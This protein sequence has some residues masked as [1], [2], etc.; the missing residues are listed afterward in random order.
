MASE[1]K[2][3][4][5]ARGS[6]DE[7]VAYF[8]KALCDKMGLT[9]TD[10][11]DDV[12]DKLRRYGGNSLINP[13][14]GEGVSYAEL[15][16]DVACKL[17]GVFEERPFGDPD[18]T[19]CERYVLGKM[20][21]AEDDLDKLCTA[22]RGKGMGKAV[23]GQVRKAVTKGV[24]EAAAVQIARQAAVAAGEAAAKRAAAEAAK[25]VA[26]QVARQVLARILLAFNVVMVAWTVVDLAG[27]AFRKT[28]P[29]VTYIA[30]LRKL[31][32]AAHEA[33]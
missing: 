20:D 13:F 17:N 6:D 4:T 30:L 5:W 28:I 1:L 2:I 3:F 18:P 12:L 9:T 31:H 23:S 21:V 16:H 27:P 29:A 19:G 25:E 24:A 22:V 11:A 26:K 15:C 7:V 32:E 33:G 10:S 14:R 8:Y